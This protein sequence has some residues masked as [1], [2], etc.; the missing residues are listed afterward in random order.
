LKINEDVGK[1]RSIFGSSYILGI[2]I[3]VVVLLF[4]KYTGFP[5]GRIS[6]ILENRGF[7]LAG[8]FYCLLSVVTM[9]L[10]TFSYMMSLRKSFLISE[11]RKPK[12]LNLFSLLA[13][14]VSGI[15]VSIELVVIGSSSLYICA[16]VVLFMIFLCVE[17]MFEYLVIPT[18]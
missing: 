5:I 15:T 3:I 16:L 1:L 4:L 7:T 17:R 12:L 2:V 11:L 10:I 18:L 13:Y 6:S 9:I 8:A 14:I